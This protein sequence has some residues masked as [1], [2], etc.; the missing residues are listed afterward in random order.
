MGTILVRID[1][2]AYMQAMDMEK[3][4]IYLP[5]AVARNRS[6]VKA[7]FW[8]KFRR[9]L[10]RIPFA[11]DLLAAYYC[12]FDPQTPARVKAVLF[13]ALAY[14]IMPADAIP[15]FIAGLGFT[16]DLTVLISTI[17]LVRNHMTQ[18]HLDKAAEYL[19]RLKG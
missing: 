7:R 8:P 5:A 6:T 15:D 14:F 10:A 1:A 11:A 2:I 3:P 12:A 4:G 16:D 13:A 9:S 19:D 18:Q 17:A